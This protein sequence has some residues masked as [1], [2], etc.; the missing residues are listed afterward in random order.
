MFN[1][2]NK[3]VLVT[4]GSRGIGK[5]TAIMFAEAGADVII[6]YQKD[7]ASAIEVK[8]E[9]LQH[10][11]KAIIARADMADRQNVMDMVDRS[12]KELGKIDILI[13]NA[14]IWNEN[15]IDNMDTELLQKTLDININGCFYTAM[16]VVPHMKKQKSGVI[17]NI[18]STAG[19]RGESFH[20]PYAATK[21]AIIA[22]T[23]SWGPE[24]IQHNI[25][26]NCVAPGWVDTDMSRESLDGPEG[27][28]IRSVIPV[29]RAGTPKELAGPILFMASDLATFI[30]GEILN[31]N[32]GAVLCG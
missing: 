21:G 23:K 24:L 25:R 30:V 3:V 28:S 8:N 15:H 5:A 32:G 10:G 7:E 29:G 16:A 12:I 20:S 19:Q 1:F 18:A 14:G 22:M 11:V 9:C 2:K 27:D 13:N 17:V 6:N 4:G 26:V 31:V